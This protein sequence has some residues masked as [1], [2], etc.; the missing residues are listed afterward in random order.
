MTKNNYGVSQQ[1]Y[2]N[3]GAQQRPDDEVQSSQLEEVVDFFCRQAEYSKENGQSVKANFYGGV[4]SVLLNPNTTDIYKRVRSLGKIANA[5][6]SI[7][8]GVV[9]EGY[10]TL[11]IK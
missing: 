5:L 10:Q 7:V 2:D 1:T 9:S 4:A 8:G 6:G 11:K 3:R